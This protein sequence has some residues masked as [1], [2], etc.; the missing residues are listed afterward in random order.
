[1]IGAITDLQSDETGVTSS[2]ER[3]KQKMPSFTLCPWFGEK[4]LEYDKV[5]EFMNIENLTQAPQAYM[6]V[7]VFRNH[8]K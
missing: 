1:M 5:L 2:K 7:D 6:K 8:V 4:G 3:G